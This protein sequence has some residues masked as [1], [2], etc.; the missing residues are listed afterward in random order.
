MTKPAWGFIASTAFAIALTVVPV[1]DEWRKPAV[2]AAGSICA[3]AAIGWGVS[4]WRGTHPPEY[5]QA[6]L[7]RIRDLILSTQQRPLAERFDVIGALIRFSDEF[8]NEKQVV[9]T[10]IELEQRQ[11]QNPFKVLESAAPGMFRGRKLEFLRDARTAKIEIRTITSAM[12]FVTKYWRHAESYKKAHHAVTG[13]Q[14]AEPRTTTCTDQEEVTE[15]PGNVPPLDSNQKSEADRGKAMFY[16][17][18]GKIRDGV[19]GLKALQDVKV[20][21]FD[22]NEDLVRFC[23]DLALHGVPNPCVDMPVPKRHW[24]GFMKIAVGRDLGTNE[25]LLAAADDVQKLPR[26]LPILTGIPDAGEVS[27]SALL[28]VLSGTNHLRIIDQLKPHVGRHVNV[29]GKLV[30]VNPLMQWILTLISVETN[31]RSTLVSCRFDRKR[32]ETTFRDIYDIGDIIIVGG[33]VSEQQN[34]QS[35]QVVECEVIGSS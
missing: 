29:S 27:L 9:W 21:E 35:L 18:L 8:K 32:W 11:F 15:P 5:R 7:I 24:L 2:I 26:P 31:E 16:T 20:H 12:S 4:H 33:T 10:C 14:Q 22:T 25:G 23:R 1:P 3:I 17:C 30:N 28:P 13:W 19:P 6:L 34:G